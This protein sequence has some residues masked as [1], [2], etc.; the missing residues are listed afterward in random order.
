MARTINAGN[1]RRGE[2]F[3]IDPEEIEVDWKQNSRAFA[4]EEQEET[5]I[6]GLMKSLQ[7]RGQIEPVRVRVIENKRVRLVAG[8]RRHE[9]RRRL[10]LSLPPEDRRPLQC[11]VVDES[12]EEAYLA[13]L[14]ENIDR[15]NHSP[16][17]Q[18][19]ATRRLG[20]EFGKT[21]DEVREIFGGKSQSW[22]DGRRLL[23]QLPK[24]I[25]LKIHRRELSVDGAFALL[26]TKPEKREEVLQ[27]VQPESPAPA[28]EPAIVAEAP[29]D[30]PKPV[31][32][33]ARQIV[34]AARESGGLQQAI[35]RRASDWK[36]FWEPLTG[37]GAK[38]GVRKIANAALKWQAGEIDDRDLEKVLDKNTVG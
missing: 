11:V 3:F 22:L 17:D 36:S 21:D 27:M 2:L 38:A 5:Q 23:L 29:K 16:M 28:S 30:A 20:Q 26:K 25:Q 15:K 24:D 34:K 18:A 33:S 12:E 9:A 35:S 37:P 19:Y 31:K 13:N 1:Y 8:Y 32:V 10:N 7:E 14:A 4:A 6:Q